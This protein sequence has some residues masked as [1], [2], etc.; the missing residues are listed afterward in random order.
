MTVLSNYNQFN[1]LHWESGTVCNHLAARGVTAPHSGQPYSEALLMGVSGGAVM[2]YF[3][4]AYEGHDPQARILTRNTFDPWDKM[5]SRLGVIQTVKQ[6]AKAEKGAQNLIDA[7]ED[8]VAPIVWADSCS[9]AYNHETYGD[10]MWMMFPLVV[11]GYDTAADQ[12]HIADR[13]FVPL[14][15]TAAEFNTARSRIKKFKH[16]LITLDPPDESKLPAAVQAGIWDTINLYTEKPPKGSKNNFGQ[17]AFQHL[18]KLL[19]KPKTRLSW[20]K[21]FPTGRKMA[22]GLRW[23]Y[24]DVNLFGKNSPAERDVY[25]DFLD[26]AAVILQK[27]T[28]NNV[29]QKYRQAVPA[30][31]A[32]SDALLPETTPYFRETRQLMDRNKQLFMTH[33]NQSIA[34]RQE[35]H[36]QLNRLYTQSENEFPL[37]AD[38]VKQHRE[39][40][41]TTL[42]SIEQIETEAVMMLKDAMS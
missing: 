26:E 25:A 9:L 41:A 5:L 39:K 32:F 13:A 38:Q 37:N 33:G 3:S 4:F 24:S 7:L 12:V 35:N 18:H 31:K 6:T 28:L 10:D 16:R 15:A 23:L 1:G 19:T 8:G 17:L 40:M 22:S 20:E 14:T 2:A 42:A 11:Y 36:Q 27:P 21:E 30:W 29:A 34:E